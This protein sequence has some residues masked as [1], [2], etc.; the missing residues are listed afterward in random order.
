MARA[1]KAAIDPDDAPLKRLGGGRWQ[2]RDERFTIEPQSGTWVVVDGEQTDDLGLP[3]VRG[4]FP[5]LTSAKEAIASARSSAPAASPLVERIERRRNAPA[6]EPEKKGRAGARPSSERGRTSGET[7]KPDPDRA[8]G[9]KPDHTARPAGRGSAPDDDER[10]EP[11]WMIDL[12]P[13][14]RGRARRLIALLAEG[15]V[16][17]AEGLVRRDL[18]GDVPALA[19]HAIAQ[20]L[21]ELGADARP[22]DVA[23]LLAEGR[24]E[25]LGVRWRLVD[26]DD[27][28]IVLDRGRRRR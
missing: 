13:G 4:P 26:G 9:S 5:S 1:T 3:L 27:R 6:T 2:T 19:A 17:D 25:A 12:E 16:T 28:P 22:T 20:R 14:R 10:R 8:P 15:G 21:A 23:E 7:G 11:G 24:D 18:V